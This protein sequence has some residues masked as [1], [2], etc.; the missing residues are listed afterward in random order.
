MKTNP[1]RKTTP[2]RKISTCLTWA[3]IGLLA[4]TAVAPAAMTTLW[5]ENFNSNPVTPTGAWTQYNAPT[6]TAFAWSS[7]T[8]NLSWYNGWDGASKFSR[9]AGLTLTDSTGFHYSLKL[10][11]SPEGEWSWY[12]EMD[13]GLSKASGSDRARVS[14]VGST[15]DGY[16]Y[17]SVWYPTK[18]TFTPQVVTATGTVLSGTVL[19]VD[20]GSDAYS[21]DVTYQAALRVLA[22][23]LYNQTDS[24]LVGTSTVTL[25]AN[26][27]FSLDTFALANAENGGGAMYIRADDITLQVPEPAAL[28]LLGLG[29]LALG[30]RRR[31]R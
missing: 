4:T 5:T 24:V 30:G 11:N 21:L 27:H 2:I 18:Y 31:A 1:I 17:N 23:T 25:G 16:T 19:K 14:I 12:G 20:R 22:F 8:S 28:S 15:T 29:L 3:G 7:A 26:D 13:A 9:A 10:A 6:K